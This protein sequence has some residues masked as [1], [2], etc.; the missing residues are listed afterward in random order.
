MTRG[1][2]EY[3]RARSKEIRRDK[4]DFLIRISK[5]IFAP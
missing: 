1:Y 2:P 3:A 5:R 4:N